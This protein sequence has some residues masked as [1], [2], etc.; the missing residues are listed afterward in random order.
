MNA[1]L[2]YWRG[3]IHSNALN[4]GRPKDNVLVRPVLGRDEL[5]RGT[6][7]LRAHRVH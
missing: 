3:L 5:F 6:T 1:S 7:V 2:D 4:F